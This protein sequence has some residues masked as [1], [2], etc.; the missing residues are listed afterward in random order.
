MRTE[1]VPGRRG[2]LL[3]ALV[4]LASGNQ[5]CIGC[6]GAAEYTAQGISRL[7]ELGVVCHEAEAHSHHREQEPGLADPGRYVDHEAAGGD[8]GPAREVGPGLLEDLRLAPFR[9]RERGVGP[10]ARSVQ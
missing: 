1:F 3:H 8:C 4:T 6:W 10:A 7:P 9:A 2:D 5:Q